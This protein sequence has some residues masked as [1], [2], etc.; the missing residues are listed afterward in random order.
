LP[1]KNKKV[2]HK[3]GHYSV[4]LLFMAILC[5]P[6][7]SSAVDTPVAAQGYT[8]VIVKLDVPGINQLTAA[9]T[10]FGTIEP[11]IV[12][13]QAGIDAD[14]AL[15]NAIE[16]VTSTVLHSLNGLDYRINHT[17]RTLPYLALDVSPQAMS[18]IATL[19]NVLEIV[20][21]KPVKLADDLSDAQLFKQPLVKTTPTNNDNLSRTMLSNT[22]KVIGADDAWTMGYTGSG[23]YVAIL[24][25]GI[26]RTHQF[27]TGKTIK[28]A[29]FSA[30][31]DCPNGS[32]SMTGTG[33]AAHYESSYDGYDHGT[34]VA[35]IATGN[36]GSLTGV[37]KNSNIIAVQVFSRFGTE[38]C[39]GDLCVMSYN[40]DQVAGLEYIYTLRG[41]YS[42]GAV[43]MS[44][45]GGSYSAYCDSAIQKAAI[46]NLKSANI[47]TC[48]ATGNNGYCGYVGSPSCISSAVAVGATTDSDSEASFNNWHRTLTELFAPGVSVYSSIG[49]SN[50]SYKS[51][52]GTSM[53]TPHV[54]GAWALL[55]QAKSSASVTDIYNALRS[56]GKAVSSVCGTGT[57]PRIDVGAAITQLLGGSSSITVTAPNGAES[58]TINSSRNITWTSSGTVGNVKIQYS[59]NNGSSWSTVTSSTSND[60]S[61]TWT[62]PNSASAQCKIKISEASDGSPSD[63]SNAVFSIITSTTPTIAVTS[64]NGG[65][66]WVTSSAHNITWSTTNAVGNVKIEYST[67]NGSNWTVIVASTPNDATHPWTLPATTSSTC[68]VRVSE[69]S[70]SSPTDT[71]NAV[72]SIISSTPPKINLGRTQLN[73]GARVDNTVTTAQTILIDNSGAGT[74]TWT[75]VSDS[76]WLSVSPASG[77]QSGVLTV[78]ANPTGLAAGSYS[79]KITV[80]ASG[81]SNTPRTISVDL[82]VSNWGVNTVPF[83]E[84]ATPL[85]GS[86]GNGSIPVTGWALDDIE[87]VSV[88]IY[89]GPDYVGDAVFVEGSR[90]DVAAAY[91][92]HPKSY[93]AGWGYMLLTY[94]LPGGGN[95]Y[96]TLYAVATDAEGN[97]VSLGS[98]TI[99]L[100]NNSAVK[101]FGALDTPAQGGT[102]AGSSFANWGWVLTPQPH[103]IATNGSKIDVWVDGVNLG[104]PTYNLYRS[105]IAT[106]FPGYAN[107][108]G[109]VGVR[110]LNTT[111]YK[112]GIHTIQWTATDS[113]GD[114]DGI[115]SRYFTIQNIHGRSDTAVTQMNSHSGES[116]VERDMSLFPVD[117]VTPVRVSRG[118]RQDTELKPIAPDVDGVV[119]TEIKE[120]ERVEMHFAPVEGSVVSVTAL[121][122]LPI[123]STLDSQRGIFYWQPG[124]GFLGKYRLEFIRESTHDTPQK[125]VVEIKITP[126]FK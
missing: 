11:G 94:F 58:W 80:S 66:S 65:E 51:W 114:S 13:P 68:L 70:D 27:F 122:S 108:N 64:P 46:D 18:F 88:K 29:C 103:S 21:D 52:D 45:G 39:D 16:A 54:T 24:D 72:F 4:W 85:D 126:K 96:Y 71:S 20:E 34:H 57:V 73:F 41:S 3:I 1:V 120:L 113:G 98:K 59:S 105:D 91:P 14:L 38:D 125:V 79:G 104:H 9:S 47:A 35:G 48:I 22:V 61:F 56:T 28:E 115:G 82:T 116:T 97:Q 12:F 50:S 121:S 77:S 86:T 17:Y 75:T 15:A 118:Y 36:Y 87:V 69:A 107:S 49:E 30:L 78:T 63:A 60:G 53:A 95:G 124:A 6:I 26:L 32:T 101:P 123:G 23:W 55:R 33:S 42:I 7:I 99:N 110:T 76:S 37:A 100:T 19:P 112:N 84:F 117:S 81:A 89:N 74:L 93:K 43:N 83:G 119:T 40:S 102:A 62:V 2:L 8:K 10:Q 92:T 31:S 106:L 109:A 25:T 90:P 67:N 111:T 5:I 44:L